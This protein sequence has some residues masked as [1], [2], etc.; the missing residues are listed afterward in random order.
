[1]SENIKTSPLSEARVFIASVGGAIRAHVGAVAVNSN[2]HGAY[3]DARKTLSLWV[4]GRDG[5]RGK[6]YPCMKYFQLQMRPILN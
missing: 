5:S 1:M 4:H 6:W 2:G 3:A